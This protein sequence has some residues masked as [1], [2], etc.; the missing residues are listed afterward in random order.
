MSVRPSVA[1]EGLLGGYFVA[2]FGSERSCEEVQT[3]KKLKSGEEI[4]FKLDVVRDVLIH[5]LMANGVLM[6]CF[7][8]V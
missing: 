8:T 6:A 5:L 1:D 4:N 2:L 7:H 3:K